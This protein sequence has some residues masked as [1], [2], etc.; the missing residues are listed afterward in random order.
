MQ[1]YFNQTNYGIEIEVNV[2]CVGIMTLILIRPTMELK[3]P[4]IA[5]RLMQ[6][7]DFNQTN[8]GI[9]IEQRYREEIEEQ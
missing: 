8:Y 2:I 3:S 4:S 5:P 9:E 7:N 1:Y 6:I